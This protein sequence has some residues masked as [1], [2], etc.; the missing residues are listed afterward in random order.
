[1]IS[2][3][4]RISVYVPCYNA[5]RYIGKCLEGIL[6]QTLKPCEVIVVDDG[7]TDNTVDIASQYPVKI[8]RHEKNRGL[9]AARNTGF[10]NS[11]G[12]YVA[13]FDSDCVPNPDWLE[14]AMR[15]FTDD[16]I[17]GVG[18]KMVES[19]RTSL[20]DY[21]RS[22]HMTQTWGDTRV[23]NPDFLF[24]AD[25]VYRKSAVEKVGYF[26]ERYRTNFEDVDM[27]NRLKKA[28]YTIIYDPEAFA[29]HY[30]K[31]TRKSLLRRIWGWNFSERQKNVK[32]VI[33]IMGRVTQRVAGLCFEDVFY[34]RDL[35]LI[36][37]DLIQG[38][39][40]IWR[41]LTFLWS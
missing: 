35:R 1:M 12:E 20:Q 19:N 31:D 36:A 17:G 7:S 32:N 23:V 27:C 40:L 38:P 2:P 26:N 34:R 39:Y 15:N 41:A 9:A 14:K 11:T 33:I 28:G 30:L 10:R 4:T 25:T 29:R 18:G 3:E 13:S 16:S 24:G 22:V 8:V 5:G 6:S 21:W 37:F